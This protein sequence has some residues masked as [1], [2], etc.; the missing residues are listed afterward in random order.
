[1]LCADNTSNL[2]SRTDEVDAPMP[3]LLFPSVTFVAGMFRLLQHTLRP[4]RPAEGSRLCEMLYTEPAR[5]LCAI[6]FWMRSRDR[7]TRAVRL[8]S[9]A[10]L[11]MASKPAPCAVHITACIDQCVPCPKADN[12][13][14]LGTFQQPEQSHT[15]VRRRCCTGLATATCVL[16]LVEVCTGMV[17]WSTRGVTTGRNFFQTHSVHACS[18]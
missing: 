5:W 4:E 13:A 8:V 11:R 1:M 2:T 18:L 10:I 3:T 6:S 15:L 17:C 9:T 7:S 16:C 12:R 14:V